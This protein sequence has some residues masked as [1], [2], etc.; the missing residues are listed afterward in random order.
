MHSLEW[1]S[2]ICMVTRRT[3][4]GRL[5]ML[6]LIGSAIDRHRNSYRYT[7]TYLSLKQL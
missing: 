6:G 3:S 5:N 4:Y 7:P 2:A 1:Y